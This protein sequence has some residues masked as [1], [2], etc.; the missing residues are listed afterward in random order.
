MI[1]TQNYFDILD[2]RKKFLI[3]YPDGQISD[4][5]TLA[6]ASSIID[7]VS[8]SFNPLHNGHKAIYWYASSVCGWH[9]YFEVSIARVDKTGYTYQEVCDILHQFEWYAPVVLTNAPLYK[10]KI[11]LFKPCRCRFH[12][13]FDSAKRTLEMNTPAE[14]STNGTEFVVYDRGDPTTKEIRSLRNLTEVPSNFRRAEVHA[15]TNDHL[16]EASSLI[17]AKRPF[18][19][20]L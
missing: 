11:E 18:V 14:L 1:T 13:G 17:R 19:G 2:G 15:A 4:Y 9:S 12:L 6:K 5:L 8:G 20:E 10:E 7:I 3:Q 16:W